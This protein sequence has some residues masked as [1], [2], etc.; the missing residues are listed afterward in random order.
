MSLA[1]QDRLTRRFRELDE[2][3]HQDDSS[4]SKNDR[5]ATGERLLDT[6]SQDGSSVFGND[7]D[8]TSDLLADAKN[9]DGSS[10]S[11]NDGD[12]GSSQSK[13]R[14][15]TGSTDSLGEPRTL[16]G[17]P[18]LRQMANSAAKSAAE[19]GAM[20]IG[21]PYDFEF[22]SESESETSSTRSGGFIQD[23]P[24]QYNTPVRSLD[25]HL[26]PILQ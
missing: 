14:S 26:T 15:R 25:N 20:L 21:S 16:F 2:V 7:G 24:S 9:Q 10:D 18:A 1:L 3:Q 19:F 22:E 6:N 12:A 5:G 23:V 11:E 13:S 8:A 4:D 17:S